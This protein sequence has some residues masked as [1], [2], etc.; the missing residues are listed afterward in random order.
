[1]GHPNIVLRVKLIESPGEIHEST[2]IVGYLNLLLLEM[3]AEK[4]VAT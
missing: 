2:I 4:S 3:G 1:M